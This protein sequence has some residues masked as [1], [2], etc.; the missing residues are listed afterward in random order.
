MMLL[1]GGRRFVSTLTLLVE[2]LIVGI[3][4]DVVAAECAR[5]DG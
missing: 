5:V 3:G 2:R 4:R 1:D